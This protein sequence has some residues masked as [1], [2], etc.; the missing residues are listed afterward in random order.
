MYYVYILQNNEG[1]LYKGQTQDLKKR[2]EEHN[3]PDNKSTYTKTR[4][5]WKLIYKEVYSTRGEAMIREKFFKTGAGREF[6]RN[7]AQKA[8]H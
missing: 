1:V 8:P 3:S 7:T 4:G 2:I 6:I 5:P